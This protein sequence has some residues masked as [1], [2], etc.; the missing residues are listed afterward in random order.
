[1]IRGLHHAQIT[2]P[3]DAEDTA[4]RFRCVVL[5]PT[6]IAKPEALAGRGG[7][8]LKAGAHEVHMGTSP[9]PRGNRVEMIESVRPWV[10][11]SV[12]Q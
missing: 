6:E 1:M 5:G 11:G 4:R 10:R 8:W 3:P 12:R 2:I 9:G 7:F